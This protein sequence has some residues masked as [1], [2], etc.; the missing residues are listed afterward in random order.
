MKKKYFLVILVLVMAMFLASCSGVTT[1]TLDVDQEEEIKEIVAN[2]W[3]ALSNRQYSLAKNYCIAH[4]DFY[5]LAEEYQNMPYFG[6]TTMIFTS[7]INWVK[8][9]GNNTTVN[10][11]ITISV[12]VCF[13]D[14]CSEESE[15]LYNFPMNLTKIGGAWKLR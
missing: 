9:T 15:T 4:G 2:Y 8:I 6:S 7:Y 5:N 14:I 1:P 10:T 3:T 13:E 12:N 11:N